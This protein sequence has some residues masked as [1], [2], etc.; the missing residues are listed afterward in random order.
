[1]WIGNV[2]LVILNLP[3]VG[4]W[5]RILKVPY[6]YLF[7]A[8]MVFSGIGTYSLSNAPFEL[9]MVA[10]FGIV[11]FTWRKLDCPPAPMMLGFVLGP[12]MEEN[13]RRSMLVSHGD[14][15]IFIE[16][17]ISLAFLITTVLIL[18]TM[19]LP[20]MKKRRRKITS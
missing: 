5:V 1:M 12:M 17:P 15:M 16:R 18:I 14:P 7:P 3:L 10:I 19:S 6:R 20:A 8:I 13:L 2:I 11:G 4:L 9:Y